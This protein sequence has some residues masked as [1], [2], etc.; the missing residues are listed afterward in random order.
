MKKNILYIVL[1]A[2]VVSSCHIYKP[3]KRPDV[4]TAGVYRDPVSATDTLAVSDTTNM[5]N[6]PWE[7]VFTDPQLQ[8]L[9]RQGLE[10]NSD[11][12][13]AAL[14]VSQAEARL[15]TSRLSFL[16]SLSLSPQGTVSSFDK[17]AAQ[18]TYQL[19]V[20][21]SW[22]IDLFGRLL[23]SKRAAKTA[24]MQSE[25]YK[26]AV[27]TQVISTVANY[28][29]TLLMLDRQ[30]QISEQTAES[31]KQNVQMMKDL[32]VA[33]SVNEAAVVQSEANYYS[34]V[35][36]LADLRQQI[37]STENALSVLLGQAPQMIARST[38][39]EQ[40]FPAEMNTGIPVQMLSNRPD[41]RS[42][43]MALAGAYYNTNIARSAFYPNLVISGSAGW[44][45]S[46]GSVIV[47]PGK[48]LASAVASLTQP[49]F[50]RGAN[51]AQ[52]KIAKAQQEEA[53][54]AFQQSILNAG[55]EVSNALVQYQTAEEKLAQ[56]KE[57]IKSLE[58]SVKYTQDLLFLDSSHTYL[59][60]LTAQQSLLSAQLSEVSDNF[61]RMQSVINLYHALG[62]GR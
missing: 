27:R 58:K 31:W 44:T 21:A 61:Q 20:V 28:Y 26:Q 16:P 47:N 43:E 14:Q 8:Q 9:I 1:L 41:V 54:I 33:G 11:L 15:M 56:R 29:Y 30:L 53:L 6:L 62:G 52:L 45:N 7:Q 37:S 3:Y 55:S 35:A 18:W 10:N 13:T 19:P 59:E 22:E 32:K 17:S 34:I 51:I 38:I 4:N 60:V 57:Q 2:V 24:L 42:A 36:S 23:N 40:Q 48:I 25:A 46:A 49:I 50:G 39:E 12:K 5:G